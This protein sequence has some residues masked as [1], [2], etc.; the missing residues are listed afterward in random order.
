MK[1]IDDSAR[2]SDQEL[3]RRIAYLSE[4][5]RPERYDTLLRAL[6]ARTRYM[7][8]CT[9][10]TFHP[11]NASALVRTCEA[12]GI[13]EIHTAEALCPFSPTL[14]IVRGTDKWVEINRYPDTS[15]LIGALRGRGYRI[16]ATTP[17]LN[18]STPESF[19]LEEGP[20]ALVFGTELTG[21]SD[22]MRESADGFLQIPMCGMVESLNVSACAAILLYTLTTRLRGSSI[23]WQLAPRDRDEILYGWLQ[24]SLRDPQGIL[25]RYSN[26]KEE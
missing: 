5:M 3:Q 20:F 25:Q 23:D 15:A 22:Q 11:Q 7:T 21:I 4:F 9:E 6:R 26:L 1:N 18:D 24:Q 14:Q 2:H 16:I 19:P 13:Q 17:H 8:L 12:F 10:D